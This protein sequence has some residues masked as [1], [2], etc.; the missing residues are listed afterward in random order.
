MGF[1][2]SHPLSVERDLPVVGS[3]DIVMRERKVI[4]DHGNSDVARKPEGGEDHTLMLSPRIFM[5]ASIREGL[6]YEQC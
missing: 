4:Y 6:L 3:V 5:S 1:G 2:F